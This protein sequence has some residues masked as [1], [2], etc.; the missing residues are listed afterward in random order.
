VFGDGISSIEEHHFGVHVNLQR[1]GPRRVDLLI[2]AGGLH[3][4]VRNLVFGPDAKFEKSLGYCVA[5]LEADG[6]RPREKLV[7]IA[8]G[9]PGPMVARF[10][11]RNDRTLFLFVFRHTVTAGPDAGEPCQ[12]KAVPHRAFEGLG[13]EC[14]H[15]LRE[16]D[17]AEEI[18][19]DP[20]SQIVMDNWFSG[21]VALVGDAACAVSFLAAER[22]GLAM[23]QAYVLAGELAP[24]PTRSPAQRPPIR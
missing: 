5:A 4:P 2:G 20:V 24:S 14:P 18:S 23:V 12:V 11:L 21:R 8:H 3:W 10:A 17:R 7:Y 15:I 22:A 1:G 6:Y 16:M 9:T 19:F 13:W